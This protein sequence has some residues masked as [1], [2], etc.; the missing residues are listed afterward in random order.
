MNISEL[1]DPD[2]LQTTINGWYIGEIMNKFTSDGGTTWYDNYDSATDTYSGLITGANAKLYG[3]KV[4]DLSSGLLSVISDWTLAEILDLDGTE[5]GILSKLGEMTISELSDPDDLQTTINGWYIGEI[6]NKFTSD[7]GTTWYNNYNADTGEYSGLIE[8]VNAKLYGLKVSD[9]SGGFISAIGDWTLA[10]ILGKN[11]DEQEG[12]DALLLGKTINELTSQSLDSIAS[13]WYIG[14]IMGYKKIGGV[15]K[16]DDVSADEKVQNFYDL[17]IGT[18]M[19]EDFGELVSRIVADWKV[20]TI[21]GYYKVG[22]DWYSDRTPNG[23]GY[24]YDP[25]DK[26]TGVTLKLANKTVSDLSGGFDSIIGELTLGDVISTDSNRVLAIL[27][28]T[29]VSDIPSAMNNLEIGEIMGYEK[30]GGV[31]KKNGTAADELT[32]IIANYK[33]NDFTAEGFIGTLKTDIMENVSVRTFF[34]DAGD[35]SSTNGFMALIDPEW[36]LGEL[37]EKVSGVVKN[38]NVGE[39]IKLNA[40]GS[41]LPYEIT[42]GEVLT[43][44]GV[45]SDDETVVGYYDL[46]YVGAS[47]VKA[48]DIDGN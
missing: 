26:V 44:N 45:S 15:W 7:G 3:L 34:P 39:L 32:A 37:T 13:N 38:A 19:S 18:L 24:G 33:I 35:S 21:L 16:K 22:D 1:S 46:T 36:K 4:S 11:V 9:L 30:V 12:I 47:Q 41:Y 29:P 27:A 14:E 42:K 28:D 17:T 40:F 6:M 25:S 20:G 31:W 23:S 8:G 5:T 10:E 43:Q 2:D 48:F